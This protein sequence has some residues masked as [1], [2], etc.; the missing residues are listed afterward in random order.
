MMPHLIVAGSLE[1]SLSLV[2]GSVAISFFFV[3]VTA[4]GVSG[5]ATINGIGRVKVFRVSNWLVVGCCDRAVVISVANDSSGCAIVLIGDDADINGISVVGRALSALILLL[6]NVLC[7]FMIMVIVKILQ[8]DI[9]MHKSLGK[10]KNFKAE[11][12]EAD[13]RSVGHS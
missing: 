6:L 7:C 5:N 11:N 2:S 4:I 8:L 13:T 10:M 9:S 3:D 12:E 1:Y